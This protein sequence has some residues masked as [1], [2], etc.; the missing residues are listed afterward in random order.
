MKPKLTSH[1]GD[2]TH[3]NET[4]KKWTKMHKTGAAEN[5]Y[6]IGVFVLDSLWTVQDAHGQF[7]N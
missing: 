3:K 7:E 4:H 6:Y 1:R 5:L 2:V